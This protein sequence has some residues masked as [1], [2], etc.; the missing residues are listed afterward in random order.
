MQ[1]IMLGWDHNTTYF[2]LIDEAEGISVYLS[3]F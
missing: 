1:Y 3:D 2:Q